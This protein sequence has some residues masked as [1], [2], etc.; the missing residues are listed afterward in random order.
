MAVK[1]TNVLSMFLI[2]SCIN[3]ARIL[4]K[5]TCGS[6]TEEQRIISE[7]DALMHIFHSPIALELLW[8]TFILILPKF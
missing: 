7:Q 4:M 5:G 2:A 3:M 1:R 6:N 8:A